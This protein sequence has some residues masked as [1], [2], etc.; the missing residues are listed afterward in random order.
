MIAESLF[1][2][3]DIPKDTKFHSMIVP[4]YIDIGKENQPRAK[5]L[6]C[7]EQI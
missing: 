7:I 4:R 2:K 1:D 5:V 6:S 3:F